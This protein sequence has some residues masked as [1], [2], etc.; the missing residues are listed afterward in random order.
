MNATRRDN[1]EIE[2]VG[3]RKQL[4]DF[5]AVPWSIYRD[6]LHWVPPLIFEQK[7]RLT[8]KNPFFEH[9]RWQVWTAR[10]DGC[11]VGRISAQID[12][13]YLKQHA[14]KC[15][16]F[17]MVEAEDDP[18]LFN[19][20]L[21]TAEG[22]LRDQGMHR[23]SGPFNLSINEE[24]GLL[25]DGFETPPFIMMGHAR[26]YYGPRLEA[27]GYTKARDLIA[28][29]INTDYEVPRVMEKLIKR[30][31]ACTVTV[32]ATQAT[33][34]GTGNTARHLQRRLVRKLGICTLHRRPNLPT[35]GNC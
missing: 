34:S 17:G 5:I 21:S 24:C 3:G 35:S 32:P 29:Y 27:S 4:D 10:H 23:V 1:F 30:G 8:K 9:A 31:K 18:A 33:G 22:W 16:Y 15:G 25:V 20:L 7:Q 11:L 26:S 14:D 13:L 6:D 28:Y 2:A 12:Q 19:A